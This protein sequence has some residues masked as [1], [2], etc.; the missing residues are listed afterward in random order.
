MYII[1][2]ILVYLERYHM[3]YIKA[4]L[5]KRSKSDP[6]IEKKNSERKNCEKKKAEQ[7]ILS[8]LYS[9]QKIQESQNIESRYIAPPSYSEE[10]AKNYKIQK[11][12][13]NIHNYDNMT[14]YDESPPPPIFNDSF[15]DSFN[16]PAQSNQVNKFNDMDIPV[17]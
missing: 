12:N 6:N 4:H 17:Y 14:N 5:L 7:S 8:T 9:E 3:D 10:D 16:D 11:Y 1:F 13:E 15:N 2:N